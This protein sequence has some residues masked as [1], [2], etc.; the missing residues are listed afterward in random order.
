MELSLF[1]YGV[2]IKINDSVYIT[3]AVEGHANLTFC[4][5]YFT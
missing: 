2:A 4:I 3:D 1:E 5:W